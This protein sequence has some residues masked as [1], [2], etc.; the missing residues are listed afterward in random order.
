MITEVV[1]GIEFSGNL[2]EFC[3]NSAGI[4]KIYFNRLFSNNLNHLNRKKK[5]INLIDLISVLAV[6]RF[7]RS[8]I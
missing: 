7:N 2:A 4:R 5:L 6:K 1:H 8:L 3:Q